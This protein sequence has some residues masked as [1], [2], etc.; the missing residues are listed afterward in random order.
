MEK[1]ISALKEGDWELRVFPRRTRHKLYAPAQREIMSMMSIM[2]KKTRSSRTP[3]TS[4][5]SGL[6]VTT[7]TV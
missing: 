5:F 6:I 1:M 4:R 2:S 7:R 3:A